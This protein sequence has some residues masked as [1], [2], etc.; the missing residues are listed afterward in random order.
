MRLFAALALSWLLVGCPLDGPA[1]ACTS[2]LMDT[3]DGPIFGANCDLF[4][5]GDG[6]VFVNQRGVEKKGWKTNTS[7]ETAEWTS[8]YGSVTFSLCGREFVWAGMNE[9]GLVA[10]TMQLASGEYP[11]P[12][13]R[14][15]LNDGN[16]LQY[17]LDACGS[18][19]EAIRMCSL[20][21]VEDN[22]APSH[23]LIADESGNCAAIEYIDGEFLCHTGETLPVEAMANMPYARSAYAYEHGG[24]RWWWSNPGQSAERVAAAETRSRNFNASRDT[25]AVNYAFGTL[26]YYVAAPHTRWN[27]VYDIAKR[28]VFFRSSQSPSY[29][30][31]SFDWFDFSCDAPL[32]MLDVN[33]ALEGDVKDRFRP[34]DRSVNHELFSTFCTRW[35]IKVSEE[36]TTELL[37]IFDEYE[38]NR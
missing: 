27:I 29:K 26:V 9:A 25:S 31:I 16:V 6:L 18:V 32:L 15:P 11:E 37:R 2:F 12:D 33:T 30:R 28:E 36:G 23:Y 22:G 8:E 5:P 13:S 17:L 19:D 14:L 20:V 24:T 10:S 35:G 4:I 38:C 7:G 34:Y 3:P 1:R 21:R